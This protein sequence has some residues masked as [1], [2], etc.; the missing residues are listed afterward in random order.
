ML[1]TRGSCACAVYQL[2]ITWRD[3]PRARVSFNNMFYT[4]RMNYI[5]SPSLF[6]SW[7]RWMLDRSVNIRQ[8]L[9]MR[10][11]WPTAR[12]WPDIN[13]TETRGHQ[14]STSRF[15]FCACYV[16]DIV[17]IV[18]SL[19]TSFV[20]NNSRHCANHHLN[21]LRVTT[22]NAKCAVFKIYTTYLVYY[23]VKCVRSCLTIDKFKYFGKFTFSTE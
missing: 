7:V 13:T 3:R 10:G 6:S 11:Q 22:S 21:M 4:D 9:S 5:F 18:V 19:L 8:I 12:V 2:F 15:S 23:L 14:V 20:V 1:T 17:T 16:V